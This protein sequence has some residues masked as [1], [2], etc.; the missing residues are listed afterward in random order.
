MYPYPYPQYVLPITALSLGG[1][2]AAMT[3]ASSVPK[4][5]QDS[6][7]APVESAPDAPEMRPESPQ[8][9]GKDPEWPVDEYAD[10]PPLEGIEESDEGSEIEV[11]GTVCA[12]APVQKGKGCR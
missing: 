4:E 2:L 10:M 9:P 11:Q 7:S 3:P 12:M 5:E 1:A 8:S 6:P